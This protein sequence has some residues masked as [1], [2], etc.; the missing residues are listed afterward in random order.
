MPEAQI[1][2]EPPKDATA[3]PPNVR[4]STSSTPASL[5]PGTPGT[6]GRTS[7]VTR[8][9][10]DFVVPRA[11]ADLERGE[12]VLRHANSRHNV[13]NTHGYTASE[14]LNVRVSVIPKIILPAL[15]LTAWGA[16]WTV[17]FV[18]LKWTWVSQ[19]NTLI[20]ILGVVMGLL[21]VFRTNTAYDRYWEARRLWGSLFTQART[22]ARFIWLHVNT[23]DDKDMYE[24]YGAMNLILA[25]VVAVKHYL[26]SE[27]GHRY[28]DLY[29]LLVHLPDYKPGAFHPQT[30]SLPIE[31]S[32][33]LSSYIVTCRK[34]DQ[35]DIPSFTAMANSLT[36]LVDIVGNFERIRNSPIPLAYSVHLK[37]TL[38]VYLLTLPFQLVGPMGWVTIPVVFIANFTLQGIDAIAGEIENPFGYDANDL[39]LEEFCTDIKN[40]ITELME[41][42]TSLAPATW[43][44]PAKMSDFN[45]LVRLSHQR[46]SAVK[47]AA[48]A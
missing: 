45:V 1:D 12:T 2:V 6:L 39:N 7:T 25:F 30:S 15:L 3:A 28:E 16:W 18:V 24:K 14:V 8:P 42:P 17:A 40:E 46:K 36:A 22:L 21:L 31:I 23:T 41:R 5:S 33:H 48:D 37:Q 34:R 26:R 38:F 10:A 43:D 9:S 13:S 4:F 20:T 32:L 29:H 27:N 19:S 35:I 44:R 11:S 47:A